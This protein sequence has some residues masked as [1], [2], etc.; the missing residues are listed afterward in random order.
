MEKPRQVPAFKEPLRVHEDH[1]GGIGADA[2]L[3]ISDDKSLVVRQVTSTKILDWGMRGRVNIQTLAPLAKSEFEKLR[4]MYSIDAPVRFVVAHND[5]SEE[6][7]YML[8][9]AVSPEKKE[10]E[11]TEAE[12]KEKA[13]NMYSLY[14]NILRYY[15]HAYISGKPFLNDIERSKQYVWGKKNGDQNNKF[16]LVDVEPSFS[17]SKE[18][19]QMPLQ[20]FATHIA[21]DQ[22]RLGGYKDFTPLLNQCERF[23]DVTFPEWRF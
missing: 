12:L 1:P 13:E 14:E 9:D 3:Q 22:Q 11:L 16:Y 10:Q 23:L 8:V 6:V 17:F 21:E 20:N 4:E 15:L 2:F 18:N 19:M 5:A 7:L